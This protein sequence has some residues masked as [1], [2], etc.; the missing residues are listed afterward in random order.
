MIEGQDGIGLDERA[1]RACPRQLITRA[2]L[3]LKTA[4][5]EAAT[6]SRAAP[7]Q[8]G[9]EVRA[10]VGGRIQEIQA[11]QLQQRPGERA[12]RAVVRPVGPDLIIE[13]RD[14]DPER[15]HFDAIS[16]ADRRRSVGAVA[17]DAA[18]PE[19]CVPEGIRCHPLD[20]RLRRGDVGAIDDVEAG[21][22]SSGHD[23][24]DHLIVERGQILHAEGRAFTALAAT[25]QRDHD[26][27]AE[28]NVRHHERRVARFDD[29]L[30]HQLELASEQTQRRRAVRLRQRVM[31]FINGDAHV[32]G[33]G[34][35]WR[36]DERERDKEQ[37]CKPAHQSL[38]VQ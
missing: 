5:G 29:V 14:V 22:G 30:S 15:I 23:R 18:V 25:L 17:E 36:G 11:L 24:T 2:Q 32:G 28:R 26:R 21:H 34:K 37:L 31:G 8:A 33:R 6:D 12:V 1:Q 19:A 38:P 13:K 9:A 10:S 20:A 35:C 16:H 27:A 4:A 7:A 3:T